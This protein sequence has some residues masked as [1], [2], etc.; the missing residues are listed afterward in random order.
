[1]II[2]EALAAAS[3]DLAAAGIDTPS[4]DAQLLLANV[5]KISRTILAARATEPISQKN[6]EEFSALVERR[7]KGECAAYILGKKEFRDLEFLV[8]PSVLVPRP[9]TE[10]LVEAAISVIKELLRMRN[11]KLRM[12]NE[13][14]EMSNE[15]TEGFDIY[16]ANSIKVLDLCTGSGAVAVSLK[17]EMPWLDVHASDI[18]AEALEIAKGNAWRL[19]GENQISFYQGDLYNALHHSSPLIP[20][21]SPLIPNSSLPIPNSSLPIPNSS[22]LIPHSSYSLI[23]SNPP[24]I[25][26]DEITTLSAEVQNEPRLA[27]DGGKTGLEIISRIIEGSH[28]FLRRGGSLLLEADPRQ[29]EK[30][31]SLLA[32]KGYY[33]IKLYKDLG[34]RER[35]IGGIHE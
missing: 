20:N 18:S 35:V 13:K 19:L 22:L 25:P 9:D 6:T 15:K 29:M 33:D 32:G 30:I 34:G 26:T 8:N 16:S 11:E 28:N 21:S 2:R 14:L 1:M 12:R 31:A 23:I 17:N 10:T 27:L 24:Y 7:K 3:A 4:L 5:L